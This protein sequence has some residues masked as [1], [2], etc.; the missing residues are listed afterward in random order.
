[1]QIS[2]AFKGTG[3]AGREAVLESYP[4]LEFDSPT[5][6]TIALLEYWRSPERRIREL[7][8]SLG[9]SVPSQTHLNFE[10]RVRPP[11]GS[12]PPSHTDLMI[13]SPELAIAIE[14]KWTEPR[15]QV[16]GDWLANSDNR[17]NRENVLRGWCDFLKRRAT[18]PIRMEELRE[19]PYQMIHRAASACYRKSVSSCWLIYLTFETTSKKRSEYLTDLHQLRI[20][21]G[22]RSSL[23]IALVECN[24]A[25]SQTLT[26]LRA[27]WDSGER[28]LHASVRQGLKSGR[29]LDAWLEKVHHLTV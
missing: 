9:F 28:H 20:V 17:N 10:H 12:G 29:L 8:A 24:I 16:V 18:K 15:Y 21:L 22:S 14:A 25:A 23:G 1:M 6:S 5:R 2:W 27:R 3:M 13:M 4:D 26:E 11:R 19:L 7:A